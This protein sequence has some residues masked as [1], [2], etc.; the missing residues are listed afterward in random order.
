MGEAGLGHGEADVGHRLFEQFTVLG[1]RYRV[2][3]GTDH[4]DTEALE[5]AP[6]HQLHGEVQGGLATEGGQ[7]RVRTFAL[8]DV[9]DDVSREGLD[10]RG[11]GHQRVGHNRGRVGV[12]QHHPVPLGAQHLTG[13][14]PRVVEFAGLTD[15]DGS[16][17]DD[18]DR[19][20]IVAPWHH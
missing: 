10:V 14:G 2:G 16:R 1:R 11:V 4:L 3:S 18:H 9:E 5:V 8:D 19:G 13:L 6:T 7:Q 20:E 17:A 15:H 12:H